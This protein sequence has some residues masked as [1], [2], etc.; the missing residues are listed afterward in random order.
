MYQDDRVDMLATDI[1][2]FQAM[3]L[4]IS[5]FMDQKPTEVIR[6]LVNSRWDI[7]ECLDYKDIVSIVEVE[8]AKK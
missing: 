8:N 7:R 6:E 3:V 5:E 2:D 4:R 1:K